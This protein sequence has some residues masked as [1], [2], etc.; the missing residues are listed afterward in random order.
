MVGAIVDE[1][2]IIEL[3]FST[4]SKET[5]RPEQDGGR[6]ADV[7]S[8]GE[9]GFAYAE[10]K[11]KI[12]VVYSLKNANATFIRTLYKNSCCG[13]HSYH[14]TTREQETTIPSGDWLTRGAPQKPTLFSLILHFDYPEMQAQMAAPA[15][16]IIS[17]PG[18]IT[19][20][21]RIRERCPRSVCCRQSPRPKHLF[22]LRNRLSPF[23]PWLRRARSHAAEN[24]SSGQLYRML[25][26]VKNLPPNKETPRE[27]SS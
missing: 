8:N 12:A 26:Q 11:W 14:H 18:Y 15:I 13:Y 6:G 21:G 1:V 4:E 10:G 22:R 9:N 17:F 16:E 3:G 24:Y 27:S 5:L 23:L 25:L 7:L 19:V 20:P 2:F